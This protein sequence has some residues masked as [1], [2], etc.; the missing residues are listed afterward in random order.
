MLF[1]SVKPLTAI[2]E[3]GTDDELDKQ[4][5]GQR[6]NESDKAKLAGQFSKNSNSINEDDAVDT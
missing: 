5:R 1:R 3:E 6:M 2:E 4:M